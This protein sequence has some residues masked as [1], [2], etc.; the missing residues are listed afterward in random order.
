M[1]LSS[2]VDYGLQAI[3][4]GIVGFALP[5]YANWIGW[6]QYMRKSK[7]KI[8]AYRIFLISTQILLSLLVL[9]STPTYQY[10][11]ITTYDIVSKEP[12][13]FW[14]YYLYIVTSLAQVI[15]YSN[16]YGTSRN[17][18]RATLYLMTTNLVLSIPI[19]L[20]VIN[21]VPMSSD[22]VGTIIFP[23]SLIYG[24]MILIPQ[25]Y[26]AEIFI[27]IP[28]KYYREADVPVHSH[29]SE[30]ILEKRLIEWVN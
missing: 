7:H 3:G 17:G 6:I 26:W 4:I 23:F 10:N 8:Q 27:N 25:G 9:T 19:R 13:R 29:L 11:S 5:I 14:F 22:F 21:N 18:A 24:F 16:H 2:N 30:K 20:I 28:E 15:L 12:I 1:K